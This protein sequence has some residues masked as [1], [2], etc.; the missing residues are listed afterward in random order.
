MQLDRTSPA[1]EVTPVPHAPSP[2]RL[3]LPGN[4]VQ[5]VLVFDSQMDIIP[6]Y[7]PMDVMRREMQSLDSSFSSGH[8][9]DVEV[10]G[11]VFIAAAYFH[12]KS[13]CLSGM[14]SLAEFSDHTFQNQ[15]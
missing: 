14:L 2:I 9:A 10:F 3:P 15:N 6:G 7:V 4:M 11:F 13:T 1:G 8:D 5:T 12:D